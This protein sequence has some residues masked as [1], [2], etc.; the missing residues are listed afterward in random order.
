ME[1]GRHENNFRTQESMTKSPK[2]ERLVW[3]RVNQ[4]SWAFC[5]SPQISWATA[6]STQ[7]H[8]CCGFHVFLGNSVFLEQC[9]AL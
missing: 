9:H 3:V 5:I 1:K 6:S 2:E 8:E 4:Q 7:H